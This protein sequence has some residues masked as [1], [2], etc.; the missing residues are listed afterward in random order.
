MDRNRRSR[1]P[2]YALKRLVADLS[3]DKAMVQDVSSKK[4]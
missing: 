4:I 3:V 2:E 1:S